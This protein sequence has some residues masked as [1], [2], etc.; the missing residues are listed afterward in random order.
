MT[1]KEIFKLLPTALYCVVGLIS[2][3]MALKGIFAK[4]FLSFHEKAANKNWDDIDP[5]LRL[6]ILSFLRLTGLGFLTISFLLI[7]CPIASCFKRNVFF[8]YSIPVIALIYCTGL[9]IT[10]YLLYRKTKAD[11][12]WKGSLYAMLIL[13]IAIVVSI[14]N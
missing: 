13:I 14:L 5:S 12:P 4:R 7:I 8:E 6:L 9:F 3:I 11:T 10:N 2:F 1:M